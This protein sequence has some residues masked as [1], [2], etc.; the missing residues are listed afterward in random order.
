MQMINIS[1]R[2]GFQPGVATLWGSWTIFRR[3]CE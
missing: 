2:G 1:S 3:G